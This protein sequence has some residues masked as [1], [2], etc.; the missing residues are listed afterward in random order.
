MA[1]TLLL[2][3][4]FAS[5]IS[6]QS[7]LELGRKWILVIRSGEHRAVCCFARKIQSNLLM[8]I[9]VYMAAGDMSLFTFN[10]K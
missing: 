9:S 3:T 5:S 10:V 1:V 2:R 8:N 6:C 4:W 7:T